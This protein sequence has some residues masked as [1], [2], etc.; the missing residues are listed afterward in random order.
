MIRMFS[1]AAPVHTLMDDNFELCIGRVAERLSEAP[2]L[3]TFGE[4]GVD[5]FHG[6]EW[7]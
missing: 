1:E 7:P 6:G 4:S 5:K 3:H 2:E